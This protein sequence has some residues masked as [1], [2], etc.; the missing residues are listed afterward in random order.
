MVYGLFF[1][2]QCYPIATLNRNLVIRIIG[3]FFNSCY[4]SHGILRDRLSEFALS[5]IAILIAPLLSFLLLPARLKAG[6]AL[7]Y[8]L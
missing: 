5:Q 1:F 4:P 8:Q 3:Y 7:S 6:C 2:I